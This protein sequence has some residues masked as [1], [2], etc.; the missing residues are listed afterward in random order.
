MTSFKHHSNILAT[1]RSMQDKYNE[2]LV[3]YNDLQI[4]LILMMILT[5]I[6]TGSV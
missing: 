2:L 4:Y 5:M 3:D 1:R 6:A